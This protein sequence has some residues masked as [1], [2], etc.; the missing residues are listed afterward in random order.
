M[1]Q[2]ISSLAIIALALQTPVP[3]LAQTEIVLDIEFPVQG[4]NSFINDFDQ[5]RSNHMHEATDILAEKMTPI[6]AAAAGRVT[7]MPIP[8]ASW[9]YAVY[10]QGDDGYSYHYLHLNNDTPGT[11]DG[12]GGLDNAYA[13]GIAKGA[14]VA[15]GQL[16]GWLGDSGNAEWTAPHLHFEIEDSNGNRINPYF[17]LVA[18]NAGSGFDPALERSLSETINSDLRIEEAVGSAS[19]TSNTLIKS[20]SITSVYYCGA[21]G[22]RYVF[23]NQAIYNS[24]YEGFDGVITI[25]E[26]QLASIPLGGN[27]TYKPGK[28]LIK[29]TSDPKVY[30]VAHGGVLR[31][32]QDPVVAETLY[33]ANWAKEVDDISETFFISYTVGDSVT[34]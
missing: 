27:V 10:I 16:I 6:V 12:N 30:A 25:T 29:I 24:W 4:P 15:R 23:P 34:Q 5:P 14:R 22:K 33:G 3:A 1:K 8:E 13:P 9:G 11:D 17:S 26:E 32:V 2:L 21:D 18:A 7:Y 31:W 19:C 28:R 20:P